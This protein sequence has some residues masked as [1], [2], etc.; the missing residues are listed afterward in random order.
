MQ[1]QMS[2]ILSGSLPK[3]R[4]WVPTMC[5]LSLRI[6]TLSLLLAR[7]F[8][9]ETLCPLLSPTRSNVAASLCQGTSVLSMTRTEHAHNRLSALTTSLAPIRTILST[10]L[11]R[12]SISKIPGIPFLDRRS[13]L[14][15]FSLEERSPFL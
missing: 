8:P 12:P 11:T 15:G 14:W 2:C 13:H 7:P 6:T 4:A 5:S 1:P 3:M 9:P 10:I